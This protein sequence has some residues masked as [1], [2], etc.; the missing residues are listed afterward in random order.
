MDINHIVKNP[1]VLLAGGTVTTIATIIGMIVTILGLTAPTN[2]HTYAHNGSSMHAPFHQVVDTPATNRIEIEPTI[3]EPEA[4][5]LEPIAPEPPAPRNVASHPIVLHQGDV[6]H[7]GATSCT[8]S[9]I[10]THSRTAYTAAHCVDYDYATTTTIRNVVMYGYVDNTSV[11]IGTA[12]IDTQHYDLARITLSDNVI[13]GDNVYSGDAL[14]TIDEMQPGDKVCNYG[15]RSKVSA[16]GDIVNSTPGVYYTS[17]NHLTK[18]D[19]G[20]PTWVV[21]AH[22]T[23]KGYIGVYVGSALAMNEHREVIT[24]YGRFAAIEDANFT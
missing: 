14:I 12:R 2:A 10:D 16:C 13:A 19:S 6:I 15:A 8:L 11:P 22:G 21:D 20:G 23:V 24:R 17:H 4:P 5:E 9:Y 3:I 18:G 7:N 1:Q